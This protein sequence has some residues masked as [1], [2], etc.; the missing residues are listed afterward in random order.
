MSDASDW[1]SS[2]ERRATTSCCAILINLVCPA[3]RLIDPS[4]CET[5]SAF[6]PTED[7]HLRYE[8]GS[9]QA[10]IGARLRELLPDYFECR[11]LSLGKETRPEGQ[12]SRSYSLGNQAEREQQRLLSEGAR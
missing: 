2:L 1:N 4:T 3:T 5:R 7:H 6:G 12:P 8:D 10:A 11:A 9:S